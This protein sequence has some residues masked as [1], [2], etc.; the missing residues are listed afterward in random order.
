M[1]LG[2]EQHTGL[3][4]EDLWFGERPHKTRGS[5]HPLKC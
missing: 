5:I 4:Y 3:I 1:Y 2:I